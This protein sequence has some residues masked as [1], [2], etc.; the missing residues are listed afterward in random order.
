MKD[1]IKLNMQV[2]F[3]DEESAAQAAPMIQ[4]RLSSPG[5]TQVWATVPQPRVSGLEIAAAVAITALIIRHT[6]AVISNT[7]DAVQ[8]L[9]RLLQQVRCL[10]QDFHAKYAYVYVGTRRVA[11]DDLSDDDLRDLAAP[12]G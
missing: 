3:V 11:I 5:G 9:R 10:M 8:E 12:P 4:Q 2:T 7:A 1:Q 6:K